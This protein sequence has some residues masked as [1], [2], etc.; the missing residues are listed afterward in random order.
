MAPGRHYCRE[1][2]VCLSE[3]AMPGVGVCRG[4]RTAYQPLKEVV[5]CEAAAMGKNRR[6]AVAC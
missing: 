1:M 6:V 4:F 5:A 2:T 3:V